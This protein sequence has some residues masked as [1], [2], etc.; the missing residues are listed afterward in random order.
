MRAELGEIDPQTKMVYAAVICS[1]QV[2]T[3]SKRVNEGWLTKK[4]WLSWRKPLH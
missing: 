2:K 4:S 1:G 3:V